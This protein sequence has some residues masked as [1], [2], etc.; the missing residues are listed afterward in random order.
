MYWSLYKPTSHHA[1]HTTTAALHLSPSFHV[2]L[3]LAHAATRCDNIREH[4]GHREYF[5]YPR[6]PSKCQNN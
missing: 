1:Q 6:T 3:S 4:H 2:Y 5:P